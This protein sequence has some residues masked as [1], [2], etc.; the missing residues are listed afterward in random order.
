VTSTA[1]TGTPYHPVGTAMLIEQAILRGRLLAFNVACAAISA[2][3]S[4]RA[5]PRRWSRGLGW[6]AAFLVPGTICVEGRL[7]PGQASED[8]RIMA[9]C[10]EQHKT[11]PDR[12]VKAQ[13]LPDMKERTKRV[14]NAPDREKP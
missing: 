10:R 11:M 13:A 9:T 5:R 12:V 7:C 14:E 4:P 2:Q 8:R 6:R 1:D 3:R